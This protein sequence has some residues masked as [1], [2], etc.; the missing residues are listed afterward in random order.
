M[1]IL[2]ATLQIV[3]KIIQNGV[4]ICREIVLTHSVMVRF[5][6]VLIFNLSFL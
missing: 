4:D 1:A 6:S 2:C 3:T 5:E